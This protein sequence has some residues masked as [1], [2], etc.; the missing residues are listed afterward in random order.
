MYE[1]LKERVY[2]ANM[3]LPE[4]GLIMLTWGNVSEVDRKAEVF[5]IKPSGIE[6]DELKPEDIVVLDLKGNVLDGDKNLSPAR[7][8][9][10]DISPSQTDHRRARVQNHP[11]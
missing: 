2:K 7:E 1:E 9:N 3:L 4:Y 5:A 6:Y 11:L 10:L 8:E